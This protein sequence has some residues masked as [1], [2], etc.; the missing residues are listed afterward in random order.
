MENAKLVCEKYGMQIA[1]I[2]S[3]MEH[4]DVI[5]ALQANGIRFKE[6]CKPPK[7]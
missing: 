3:P 2:Q 5:A 7:T 6:F 4:A 1:Q